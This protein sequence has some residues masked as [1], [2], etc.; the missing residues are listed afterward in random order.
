MINKS[1]N[2]RI[3][4]CVKKVIAAIE[5]GSVENAKAALVIAQSEVMV[6]VTKK[7]L[8]LNT[9]SR[10]ISRLARRI[11]NMQSVA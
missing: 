6:G 9:A 10:K 2:T 1:R 5:S 3:K 11:K 8:K 7:I 4:T